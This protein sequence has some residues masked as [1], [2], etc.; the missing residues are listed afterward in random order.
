MS[1]YILYLICCHI[2]KKYSESD[3]KTHMM[4]ITFLVVLLTCEK[5]VS[6]LFDISFATIFALP[7]VWIIVSALFIILIN[8]QMNNHIIT[9][10]PTIMLSLGYGKFH[11]FSENILFVTKL[12]MIIAIIYFF[13]KKEFRIKVQLF[14]WIK[15]VIAWIL[16][17][18]GSL[19]VPVTIYGIKCIEF[20]WRGALS[21]IISYGGGDAYLTTAESLFVGNII[22]AN[23]FWGTIIVVAN[24]LPGSILCKVLSEIGFLYGVSLGGFFCGIQFAIIGFACSIVVSG[25]VFGFG[26]SIYYSLETKLIKTISKWMNPVICG[27]LINVMLSIIGTFV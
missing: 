10:V 5:A 22:P 15:E 26:Y 21:V 7:V 24:L 4:I 6:N 27:L 11:L 19:L 1:I 9:F 2:Y 17:L 12:I 3:S 8:S 16:L 14:K 18:A 13:A 23:V 25:I 20:L